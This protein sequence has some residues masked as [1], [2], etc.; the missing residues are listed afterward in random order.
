ME[1]SQSKEAGRHFSRE[2]M[3]A[4]GGRLLPPDFTEHHWGLADP[5]TPEVQ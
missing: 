5:S 2:L 1:L 4:C 3:T